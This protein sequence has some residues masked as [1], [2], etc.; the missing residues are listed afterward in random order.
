MRASLLLALLLSACAQSEEHA[1]RNA[2][3]DWPNVN[4]VYVVS[5]NVMRDCQSRSATACAY[6]ASAPNGTCVIYHKRSPIATT[7]EH[8]ALHCR[9]GR[10]HG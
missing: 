9:Y 5:D 4:V 8:E 7:L 1:R 2:E 3:Y 10:W 6:P